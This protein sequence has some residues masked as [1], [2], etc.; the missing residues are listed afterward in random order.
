M[1]TKQFETHMKLFANAWSAWVEELQKQFSNGKVDA[2]DLFEK[3][4]DHF[5][6]LVVQLKEGVDQGTD[7]AEEQLKNMK[8]KLEELQVQLNLGKAEGME[9]FETQKKKIEAA[10]H[11]LYVAGKTAYHTQSGQ[12]LEL[13]DH[14]SQTFKTGL[15]ILQLQ[16]ALAKMDAKD[17]AGQM[18]KDLDAK[19]HEWNEQVKTLQQVAVH[20]MEEWSKQMKDAYEK[21]K[22]MAQGWMKK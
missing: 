13:F 10:L 3:Q 9:A 18:R 14:Q 19:M 8:A 6:K 2:A 12:L 7:L 21:M 4:K 5:R 22:E 16:F 15:E 11:E 1:D 20:N 17:E